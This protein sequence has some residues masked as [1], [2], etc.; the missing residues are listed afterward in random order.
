MSETQPYA[1]VTGSS[2]GLGRAIAEECAGRGLGLVLVA[3]PETGLPEVAEVIRLIYG[4]PVEV[5]EADLTDREVPQQ[6]ADW[7]EQRALHIELLVN[8]AGTGYN[9]RFRDSTLRENDATIELN[10]LALVRLTYLLLPKIVEYRGRILNVASLA[11]YFPMPFMPVYSPSKSFVVNFSLALREELK[12]NGVAV[13]VLCPN[14]IR[15][16][17][18]CRTRIDAQG[19]AGKLTCLYP[20]EVGRYAVRQLLRGRAVIVP[21][22]INRILQAVGRLVPRSLVFRVVSR[23]WGTE[24][25]AKAPLF[26]RVEVEQA[27]EVAHG[28]V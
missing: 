25:E 2:Q 22:W 19:F 10:V 13:S 12:G 11:A 16:N 14:G 7:I 20:D 26:R 18:S 24:A 17:Q 9:S 21:G 6:L 27:R 5:W 23:H 8:N 1:I 15:T 3:L 28:T 4:V